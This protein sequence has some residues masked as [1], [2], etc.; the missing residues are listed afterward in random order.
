MVVFGEKKS[1]KMKWRS[2][3]F[4]IDPNKL[5]AED[6]LAQH[7]VS[8]SFSLGSDGKIPQIAQSTVMCR[9]RLIVAV[10]MFEKNDTERE[11]ITTNASPKFAAAKVQLT[12][13]WTLLQKHGGPPQPAMQTPGRGRIARSPRSTTPADG[14]LVYAVYRFKAQ[15]RV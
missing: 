8:I 10:T 4:S 15:R 13:T 2:F 14:K 11:S 12:N 5:G 9:G 1:E 6:A 7:Q 3:Y